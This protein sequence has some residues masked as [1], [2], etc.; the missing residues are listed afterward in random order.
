[1]KKSTKRFLFFTAATAATIYAYNEYVDKTATSKNMLS[2]D[3]GSYF[4]WKYGDVFYTKRG[5][6]EPILLLH[7]LDPASSSFE[8]AKVI[9]KLEKNYTVYTMDLPGCGRSVKP[10]LTYTNYMYV[11]LITSFV[12]EVI[13]EKTS[14]VATNLSSTVAITS[15]SMNPDLFHQIV[16]VN[17]PS[18]DSM[19][20][21]T[22]YVCKTK[23]Y[24]LS[25][26]FAGTFL[27]NLLMNPKRISRFFTMRY[28]SKEQLIP[29]NME[30]VYYESAHLN[31]SNGRYLLASILGRYMNMDISHTLSN[32][33]TNIHIIASREL[34]GNIPNINQYLAIN[35][36]IDVTYLSDVKLLPQLETPDKF[37]SVLKKNLQ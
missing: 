23:F 33:K 13:K 21:I 32:S 5:N 34:K 18:L 24:L 29:T 3:N 10:A 22:D 30:D 36:D 4:E 9:H 25:I 35:K 6:G 2:D 1:M 28:F 31:H 11:Q 16:L 17:P 19:R 37:I 7:D 20:E 27:Y 14:L 26:P 12:K 8:W 15:N